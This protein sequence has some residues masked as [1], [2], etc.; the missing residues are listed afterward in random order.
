M[1]P[2]VGK[3]FEDRVQEVRNAAQEPGVAEHR[4]HLIKTLGGRNG[5]LISLAMPALRAGDDTFLDAARA[6]FE[7]LLSDPIKRDPQCHGKVAI[8]QALYDADV[9]SDALFLSGVAHVQLEPVMGGRQDTAAQLRGISLMALVHVQHP[10]ALVCAATMLA[11]A[12]RAARIA[13]LRALT[14]SGRDDIAE[15]L[16]RLRLG[17]GESDPEVLSE[18]MSALLEVNGHDN[19]AVMAAYLAAE[20]TAAAQAAAVALGASRLPGAL[21]ILSTHVGNTVSPERRRTLILGIAMLRSDAGWQLLIELVM[22]GSRGEAIDAIDALA[23]FK[24]QPGLRERVQDASMDRG[25]DEIQRSFEH[26]F[27]AE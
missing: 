9:S 23:T 12:E 2:A 22:E 3:K 16:L 5:Y 6:A 14:A 13:A 17:A 8:A 25:D 1:L 21:E 27:G 10:R 24:E 18:C 15:P 4:K 20:D 7:T 19:L 11:D 26:S